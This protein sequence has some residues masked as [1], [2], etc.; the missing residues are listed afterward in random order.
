M[1]SDDKGEELDGSTYLL[2]SVAYKK[3]GMHKEAHE[4]RLVEDGEA[5]KVGD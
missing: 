1:T 2:N 5:F 4:I 3:I